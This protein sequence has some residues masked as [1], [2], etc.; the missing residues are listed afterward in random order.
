MSSV[1]MA[2][3]GGNVRIKEMAWDNLQKKNFYFILAF[4]RMFSIITTNIELCIFLIRIKL[5]LL[6]NHPYNPT[7][8]I[9]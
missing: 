1:R 8:H 3:R 9:K 6:F 2:K 4:K 7:V 5:S